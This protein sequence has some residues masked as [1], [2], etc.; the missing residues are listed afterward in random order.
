MGISLLWS[1]R[2]LV[3]THPPATF[4]IMV[5]CE[6]P[7][8]YEA[9]EDVRNDKTDTDWA[10]CGYTQDGKALEVRGS[11]TGGPNEMKNSFV[12]DEPMY[13]YL[14]VTAGDEESIRQKFV[15]VSWCGPSVKALKK[16]KMS[17][18]KASFKK[19]FRE[20]AVERHYT[21]IE[22]ID[23]EEVRQM[24]IASGGANYSQKY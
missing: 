7:A 13:G 14:R 3:C 2:G 8:L 6:D 16:A 20:Y 24:V 19:V 9:Y 23:A 4:F 1:S 10:L 21:E 11:G 15:L 5:D 12:D 17:V 22:E 18:H